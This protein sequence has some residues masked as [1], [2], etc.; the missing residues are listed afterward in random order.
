MSVAFINYRRS[1]S[2]QASQGLYSQLC[3]R[4]GPTRLFLDVGAILP[5]ALWPNRLRSALAECTVILA[6]IGPRWLTASNQYGQRRLDDPNDWVRNELSFA[7]A[8]HKPVIPLLVA[9]ADALPPPEALPN[10]ISGLLNYQ[11]MTLR[12]EKWDRDLSELVE[13]LKSEYGFVDNQTSVVMPSPQKAIPPV[14]AKEL[15][16]SLTQLKG[17]EPVESVVPQHYPKPRQ[18][19]RKAYRFKSFRAA[20]EFMNE[21]VPKIN[22]LQLHPRWENQWKT[23]TVY[24]STWDIGNLISELDI[25]LAAELDKLYAESQQK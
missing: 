23:V 21:A 13:V 17:W 16:T 18:E 10:D 3:T 11:S 14:T 9:G 6:V 15:E 19:L 24:L 8:N 20:V 7:I 4:F 22:E 5:G 25:K 2:Q 1:D 12:D